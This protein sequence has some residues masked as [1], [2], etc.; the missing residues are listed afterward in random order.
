MNLPMT[1]DADEIAALRR[2]MGVDPSA[3]RGMQ[4]PELKVMHDDEDENG[5]ALPKGSFYLKGHGTE[6]V[7]SKEVNIRVMSHHFQ[8]VDFDGEAKK[9]RNKTILATSFRSDFPDIRGTLRCGRPSS[10]VFK[11]LGDAAKKKY[12]TITC[13][14]IIRG[15]VSYEGKTQSGEVVKI[16]NVPFI[17]RLKGSNFMGF[18]EEFASKLPSGRDLWD[19]WTTLSLER[20]KNGSVTYFVFHYAPQFNSPAVF[21]M[22]T[23]ETI[24]A[25]SA[26]VGGENDRIMESH[27]KAL[28]KSYEEDT[29]YGTIVD[30]LSADDLEGDLEDA[31]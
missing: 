24:R 22:P 21:D 25:F 17:V 23:V 13:Y 14:R 20:K 3:D 10:K 27:R 28:S 15:I 1:I 19:Y 11:E 18:D 30:D 31:A 16:E 4:L 6:N 12:E 5:V 29:V 9:V 2:S 8:Y 26:M 7:Y